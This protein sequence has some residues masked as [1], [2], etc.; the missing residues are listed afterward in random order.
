MNDD[1]WEAKLV[2]ALFSGFLSFILASVI[3]AIVMLVLAGLIALQG[4]LFG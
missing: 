2:R 1:P 3:V 4:A